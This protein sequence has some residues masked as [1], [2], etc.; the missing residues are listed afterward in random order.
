[1]FPKECWKTE[2]IFH[3]HIYDVTVLTSFF[4]GLLKLN[5]LQIMSN[6]TLQRISITI[7]IIFMW[8][9]G[10]IVVLKWSMNLFHFV[11][12]LNPIC[13]FILPNVSN[14]PKDGCN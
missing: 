3:C 2:K 4:T 5:I 1:M 7:I 11:L 8:L 13:C 9:Y 14:E 10:I 12:L 6:F